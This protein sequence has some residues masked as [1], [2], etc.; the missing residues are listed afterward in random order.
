MVRMLG[1]RD[2]QAIGNGTSTPA[3]LFLGHV[4]LIGVARRVAPHVS[5]GV[6]PIIYQ[7]TIYGPVFSAAEQYD[8]EVAGIIVNVPSGR[9]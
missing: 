1:A 3:V 2:T 4:P 7:N 6:A 5:R 9:L 8:L